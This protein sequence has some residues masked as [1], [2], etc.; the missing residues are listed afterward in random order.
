MEFKLT[1]KESEN[2]TVR[3]P[4]ELIE[5][6]NKAIAGKDISF[7]RFVILACDF[8]LKYMGNEKKSN[9]K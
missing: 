8:A 3:F 5:D 6:I 9:K 2:K 7:S 4:I 1:K